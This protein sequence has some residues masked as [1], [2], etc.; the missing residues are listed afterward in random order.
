M[1]NEKLEELLREEDQSEIQISPEFLRAFVSDRRR[2]ANEIG[3]QLVL[4]RTL[5]FGPSLYASMSYEAGVAAALGW[6]LRETDEPPIG[7]E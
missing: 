7:E 3:D 5:E 6:V 1:T 2:T 4:A